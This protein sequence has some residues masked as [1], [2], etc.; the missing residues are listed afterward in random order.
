MGMKSLSESRNRYLQQLLRQRYKKRR[1]DRGKRAPAHIPFQF[2][3]H[4]FIRVFSPGWKV[5]PVP[6]LVHKHA[7]RSS[8]LRGIE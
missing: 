6:Q 7:F 8:V 5:Y 3:V 1:V 4:V 2:I